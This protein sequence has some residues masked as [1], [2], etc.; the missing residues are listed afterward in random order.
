MI[1]PPPPLSSKLF[2]FISDAPILNHD[3]LNLNGFE[4]FPDFIC[5]TLPISEISAWS[6]SRFTI[7]LI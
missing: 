1:I 2:S 6:V 4:T 3:L 7:F 5:T